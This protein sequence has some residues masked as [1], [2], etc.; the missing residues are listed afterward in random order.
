MGAQ[1]FLLFDGRWIPRYLEPAPAPSQNSD[2]QELKK[3]AR[4]LW[5][6]L[7]QDNILR[8]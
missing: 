5:N 8:A 7:L 2:N 3:L 6:L 4:Q 1:T